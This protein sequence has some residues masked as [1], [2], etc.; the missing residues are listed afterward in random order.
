MSPRVTSTAPPRT[1][2]PTSLWLAAVPEMPPLTGPEG[3][4]E[5]LL[6]LLHYGIDWDGWVS[7]YLASY[8]DSVL[9]DRVVVATWRS[10]NL[11]RWWDDVAGELASRPRDTAE[12]RELEQLLRETP[13]P[14]L[15][16]L[17]SEVTSLLL[18]V[19]IV[20]DAV[21]AARPARKEHP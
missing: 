6:L 13:Q 18:R 5:R 2:S 15:E 16:V 4:A 9:P 19:R 7:R 17:R 1:E 8:W 20:A 10:D 14:V 11:R 21:R 3:T 12:R